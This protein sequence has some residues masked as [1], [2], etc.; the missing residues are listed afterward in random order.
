MKSKIVSIVAV[1]LGVFDRPYLATI[2]TNQPKV[3]HRMH[4]PKT[5]IIQE[6]PAR[7][8]GATGIRKMH[9]PKIQLIQKGPAKLVGAIETSFPR[10][11]G[12]FL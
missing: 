1:S 2:L 4:E 12:H 11:V 10:Q 7:V 3:V 5:Q 9:K 6:G 8:V